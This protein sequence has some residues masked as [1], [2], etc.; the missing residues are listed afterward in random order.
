MI[1]MS[2]GV[3]WG[4]VWWLRLSCDGVGF[5]VLGVWGIGL[6]NMCGILIVYV[7]GLV[8]YLL[9][10]FG[11][12]L[13]YLLWWFLVL[14]FYFMLWI[15]FMRWGCSLYEVLCSVSGYWCFF[16]ILW[17]LCWGFLFYFKLY[18]WKFVMMMCIWVF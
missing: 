15:L 6:R 18:M 14:V 5:L 1:F 4:V 12:N 16:R 9:W 3:C 8:I 10:C 13:C 11:C 2:I 17:M 7:V